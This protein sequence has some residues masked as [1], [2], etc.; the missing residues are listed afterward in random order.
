MG[1]DGISSAILQC[2]AVTLVEPVHHLL[3]QCLSQSYLPKEWHNHY[4]IRIPK[5]KDRPSV[6]NYHPISFLCCLSKVLER[7]VF[8]KASDFIFQNCISQCQ[9]G[10]VSN[11][12]TLKQLLLY[13]DFLY[14]SFTKRQKVDSIY[15]D[16]RKASDSVPHSK[17]LTKLLTSGI[18]GN[19]WNFFKCYLTDR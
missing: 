4:I 13:Q 7:L 9:F 2:C 11:R 1:R 17:A 18:T 12:Y 10:F 8:D 5:S 3:S 16:I 15:L 6:T 19:L 14:T